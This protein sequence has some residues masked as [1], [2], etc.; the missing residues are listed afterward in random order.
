MRAAGDRSGEAAVA[1]NAGR[2][3]MRRGEDAAAVTEFERALEIYRAIASRRGEAVALGN[4]AWSQAGLETGGRCRRQLRARRGHQPRDRA[5]IRRSGGA[6]AV[7][8]LR[9]GS[10]PAAAGPGAPRRRAGGARRGALRRHERRAADVLLRV[11]PGLLRARHRPGDA[12][13]CRR[14]VGRLGRAGA[15]HG[16]AGAWRGADRHARR[17][18]RRHSR[19]GRCG[20]ARS[21]ARARAA[22]ARRRRA[23]DPRPQR[24]AYRGTG[25]RGGRGRPHHHH[26]ARGRRGAD[27]RTS[28]S[29]PRHAASPLSA[30]DIQ[31]ICSTPARCSSNTRSA[32]PTARVRGLAVLDRGCTSCRAAPPSTRPSARPTGS[33]SSPRTRSRPTRRP[34]GSRRSSSRRS[35]ATWLQE[36]AGGGRHRVVAGDS[37]AALPLLGRHR[38]APARRPRDRD[39]AVGVGRG[40]GPS[41]SR[42]AAG[43]GETVAG[44][45]GPGVP[46]RRSAGVVSELD[47][48]GGAAGR[49]PVARSGAG[50]I[51]DNETTDLARLIGS[52]REAMAIAA[53]LPEGAVRQA[54]DF[55]AARGLVTG[56][57]PAR[58]RIVHFATHAFVNGTQP[59]LSGIALSLVDR[60]GGAAGRR[61]PAARHLQSAPHADLSS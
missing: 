10:R 27:R 41:G 58:Y 30:A 35:P 17:V 6:A 15:R 26:L 5:D 33:C 45:R 53:L 39:A 29:T 61:G 38:P 7:R 3:A 40:R 21:P 52:R 44:R 23:P 2:I 19:R 9:S 49:G 28:P 12:T 16:R 20:A 60:T 13:A 51:T 31:R 42:R 24:R 57:E 48:A 55:D 46:E 1:V 22:P 4:L 43:A 34:A 47:Q 54:L 14:P 59:E 36:A 32:P 11:G 25:H 37:F 56:D 18:T 50:W 8:P